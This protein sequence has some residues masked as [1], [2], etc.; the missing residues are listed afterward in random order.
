MEYSRNKG[1]LDD[2]SRTGSNF[3]GEEKKQSFVGSYL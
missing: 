2:P 1:V 3:H